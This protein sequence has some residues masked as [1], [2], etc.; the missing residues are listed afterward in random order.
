MELLH[1]TV[2]KIE[3]LVKVRTIVSRKVTLSQ[4]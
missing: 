2:L 1:V 4:L 3:R